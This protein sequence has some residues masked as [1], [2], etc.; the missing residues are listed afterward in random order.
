M[1]HVGAADAPV[2][3]AEIRDALDECAKI[4]QSK[5]DVLGWE[6][7]MGLHD[8]VEAESKK[9]GIQLRLIHIPREAMDR[10]AVESGDIHFYELAYLEVETEAKGKRIRL[11]LKNFVIPSTE[12][13]PEDVRRKIHKWSDYIDYWAVDF[14]YKDDVF[15]NQWQDYRTRAKRD[16]ALVSD[17]HE[18][19]KLGERQILVKVFDIFGNDTTH[20]LETRIR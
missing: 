10:R 15:H 5:L 18:Y 14:E 17:W 3:L 11:K 12:L 13:I 19:D 6:W 2:T 4:R 9:S 16:L 1:I 20:I 8:V 7:E